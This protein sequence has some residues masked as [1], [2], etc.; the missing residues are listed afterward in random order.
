MHNNVSLLYCTSALGLVPHLYL[1][2]DFALQLIL[3]YHSQY[4]SGTEGEGLLVSRTLTAFTW[5][6]LEMGMFCVGALVTV[7]PPAHTDTRP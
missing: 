4:T 1:K 6:V 5:E 7:T 2:E 3:S